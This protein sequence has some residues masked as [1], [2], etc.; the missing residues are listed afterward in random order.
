MPAER[1]Y[2]PDALA[3]SFDA[4]V[5]DIR[6]FARKDGQT[7][8]HVALNRTAFTP[9]GGGQPHDTGTLQAQARSGTALTAAIDEVVEDEAGEVWHATTK[10]LLNGTPVHGEIHAGRRLD[11]TRQHSGQHLLSAVLADR[12]GLPTVGFRLGEGDSTI[13]L[14]LPSTTTP[15]ALGAILREAELE[16]NRVLQSNLPVSIRQVSTAEAEALLAAGALGK[17]PREPATYG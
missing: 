8:W 14:A 17:L 4:V 6:E 15:A 5:T 11:H 7:V 16:A 1:L 3:L 12:Y 13:D 10:P 2:L 9:T